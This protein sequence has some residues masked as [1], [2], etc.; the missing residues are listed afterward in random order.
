MFYFEAKLGK[1]AVIS[2]V[3][4]PT[5]VNLLCTDYQPIIVATGSEYSILAV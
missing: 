4:T 5:R 2:H 1:R 3:H